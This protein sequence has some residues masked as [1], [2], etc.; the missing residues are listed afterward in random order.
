MNIL[1]A[2]DDR[3]FRK[4]LAFALEDMGYSVTEAQDGEEAI[5]LFL[6]NNYDLVISDLVM[7][8]IDGLEFYKTVKKIKP[9]T[10]FFMITSFPNDESAKEAKKMFKDNYFEKTA[11]LEKLLKKVSDLMKI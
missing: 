3:S 4:G 1:I 2:E 11:N 5:Q 10:K 8:H 6:N 9:S 7:P